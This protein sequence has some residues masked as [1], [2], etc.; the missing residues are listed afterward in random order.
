MNQRRN[1]IQ[2]EETEKLIAIQKE[3]LHNDMSKGMEQ[4]TEGLAS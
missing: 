1:S 3:R 2:T 4:K